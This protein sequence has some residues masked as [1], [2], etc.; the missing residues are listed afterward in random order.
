M[1]ESSMPPMLRALRGDKP[2]PLAGSAYATMIDTLRDFLDH[3]AAAQLDEAT[4]A[5]LDR[6]LRDHIAMLAP[7]QRDEWS[8]M[9]GHVA[10]VPGSGQVMRPAFRIEQQDAT[11]LRASVTFGSYFL[12]FNGAAHGGA[13]AAL[14]DDIFSI[15][16]NAGV[17]SIA[18]TAYLHINYRSLTPIGQEL[19]ITA[20][21]ATVDGR[22]RLVRG[23]LRNGDI[24]CA[25]AEGLFLELRAGQ[26]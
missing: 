8:R 19:H 3:V 16:A 7:L 20:K 22:K 25:D 26:H 18:R 23:E 1:A 24:L 17:P 11:S 14:F 2:A 10:G 5:D 21:V 13:V 9:F 15:P 12:G 4:S 6:R